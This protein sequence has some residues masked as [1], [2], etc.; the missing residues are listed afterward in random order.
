MFKRILIANRGEIAVR[1]ARA[2]RELDIETVAVY[3]AADRESLH[4]K[5]ADHAYPI[6]PAPSIQSYLSID[7]IIEVCKKS[8]AEAV[9]PGYGFLAENAAFAQRCKDEGIVFIGPSPQVID[10]MGDKVKARQIMKGAGVPVVPGFGRHFGLG[11][12]G[13]KDDE[14]IGYPCMLKAVAG[15]GG[16][17]L[18]LVRRPREVSSAYRAVGS[19]ASSSFGE[20]GFTSRNSSKNPATWRF[21]SLPTVTVT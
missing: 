12:R 9:H 14:L 20:P 10:Q 17:G 8:R 11:G 16:K 19:E 2:C 18:R 4:V 7:R 3:S 21:K 13:L 15:G 5:Y 6:G 1:I